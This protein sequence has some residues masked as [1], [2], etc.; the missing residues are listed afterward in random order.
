M[1]MRV[2]AALII[3]LVV[4]ATADARPFDKF[5]G[6]LQERSESYGTES[7]LPSARALSI[8]IA[9][10]KIVYCGTARGLARFSRGNWSRVA[11]VPDKP[12]PLLE[13]NLDD[14]SLLVVCDG[15][16]HRVVGGDATHIATLPPGEPVALDVAAS[17]VLLA[18]T[19]GLYELD[20]KSFRR[21]RTLPATGTI[22]DVA[23]IGAGTIALA[24]ESGLALR[25]VAGWETVPGL[26][27]VR[28]V[29]LGV[30]GQIWF[31]AA[32]GVGSFVGASPNPLNEEDGVPIIDGVTIV[33][34][35]VAQAAWFGTSQG[36]MCF[37]GRNWMYRQGR[38]WLPS[39][40]VFDI[41]VAA[42][43]DAWIATAKG[44]AHIFRRRITLSEKAR[45][46]EDEIDLRHRRTPFGF[47]LDARLATP[48]DRSSWTN[49]DSDN[50]GLWTS[51]YGAGEC[52]AYAA[53]KDPR[54]KERAKKAFEA[55]KFLGDVTQGGEHP[56]PPGFVAR[57]I[58]PMGGPDP[59]AGLLE[60]DRRF[61][62]T[63]DRQWK[64]ID[65]RWPK[66]ADGKWY[67]KSD[68][69]SDELDGHYFFYARYYDLVADTEAEKQRVRDV[70][71]RLTDHL[72]EHGYN[73]VDH[74]GTPTRWGHFSP[75]DLNLN[76]VW[77]VERG[78]NS[79]S[80]LSYL[81]VAHHVSGD[82]K[83]EKAAK[84]LIDEHG[85]AI[86][87]LYPKHQSGVGTGNQSDDEMA[88]MGF[89]DLLLYERDPKL[90]S[91]YAFAFHRYWQ[92]ERPEMN[93][94]FDFLYAAVTKGDEW[95]DASR[96]RD[97]T[98]PPDSLE[99]AFE[100][101][102]RFPL[103]LIDWPHTNSRRAD[104]VPVQGAVD[105]ARL[106]RLTRGLRRNGKVI[107][108]DERYVKHWNHDPFRL[109][110]GGD[111]RTLAD[112]TSFLLPYYLG[113]YH[114]FVPKPE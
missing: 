13:T 34:T 104:I 40:E 112:G 92:L 62:E 29:E 87:L 42:N 100:T 58:V 110:S 105:G 19:I 70:V 96:T 107:P 50:D 38:R 95:S 15:S 9:G 78:L 93:P 81:K 71:V 11:A 37:D 90:R 51:M 30:D 21:Q 65:P 84:E 5:G 25:T 10:P 31:A 74:D 113:L 8:A 63:R 12:V 102:R 85:Y 94:L 53:T 14:V 69:S 56:A 26:S 80:I 44:V 28:A 67:W 20:G 106:G 91:I 18:T 1:H 49:T 88:F 27:D 7:G 2:A 109:D 46:F 43:G 99:D 23:W 48:G 111:G 82:A 86:N 72:I 6:F 77:W 55:L 73:L 83:Y 75:A 39:D 97:L 114:G 47:V 60:H 32:Q 61:R 4:I 41:D 101:L 79:M 35:S 24:S 52:F 54:A 3:C 36:A 76:P 16:L 103:D 89:Y 98:A 108:V 33:A 17:G 66:S 45:F 68:T 59:S 64:V 57:T 22:R